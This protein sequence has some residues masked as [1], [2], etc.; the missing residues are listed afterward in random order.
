MFSFQL[1]NLPPINSYKKVF[2]NNEI[3]KV[4]EPNNINKENMNAII[5]YTGAN[6]LIPGDIY[7]E[8]IKSLNRYNFSVNVVTN[9]NSVT[10]E[11]L[12]DIR[13]EYKEIIPVSHSSGYV[14]A[15]NTINSQKNIK[16]AIFLDPV[17]NS[18]LL[19]LNPLK[20][21]DNNNNKFNYVENILI[22]NHTNG[23]Y[24]KIR[25]SIYS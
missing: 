1:N 10:K 8:F 6:S 21:M 4:Y 9:D 12:Y 3:V 18:N 17:D 11:L 24:F 7:S 15:L 25:N 20:F 22:L 16:Q 2:N 14:S 23:H 5:F 19:N 13:N